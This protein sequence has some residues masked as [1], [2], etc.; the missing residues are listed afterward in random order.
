MSISFFRGRRVSYPISQL[1]EIRSELKQSKIPFR[2]FFRG[3][4]EIRRDGQPASSTLKANAT[5]FV[6]YKY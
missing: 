2:I 6:V 3:P 5:G 1:E 4:R